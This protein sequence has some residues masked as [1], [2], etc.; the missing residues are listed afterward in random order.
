MTAPSRRAHRDP[1]YPSTVG[2]ATRS[3][4]CLVCGTSLEF[5][6]GSVATRCATCEDTR[7]LPLRFSAGVPPQSIEAARAPTGALPGHHHQRCRACG[8][9]LS[10][11]SAGPCPLCGGETTQDTTATALAVDGWLPFAVDEHAARAMVGAELPRL[12]IAAT[13]GRF[14]GVHVPWLVYDYTVRGTFEGRRGELVGEHR[15]MVWTDTSGVIDRSF[16]HRRRSASRSLVGDLAE[17]LE[18]WDWAFVEPVSQAI[19][20]AVCERCEVTPEHV[21]NHTIGDFASEVASEVGFEIGGD[22]QQVLSVDATRSD[23]RFRH[24]LVPVWFGTLTDGRT[25]VAVNGRTGEVVVADR[26]GRA[27]EESDVEPVRG[28]SPP[29]LVTI[30]IGAIV[31]VV[32]V[33][34]LWG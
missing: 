2:L 29:L 24:V 7:P 28:T 26:P 14:V 16:E 6:A 10:R 27:S 9:L 5:T 31:V 21:A 23:E 30:A 13:L 20:T 34:S 25:R 32:F 17:R 4:E 8:T 11:A 18:P 1:V 33:V 15:R 22:A 19:A 3:F 12:R